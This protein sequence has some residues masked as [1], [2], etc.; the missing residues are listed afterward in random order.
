MTRQNTRQR[1]AKTTS[2]KPGEVVL[3]RDDLVRQ[4]WV[5]GNLEYKLWPQQKPIYHG[6][7]GLPASVSEAVFLCARQFGKSHLGVILAAE[8]C[9][10]F[11][12]SC[13]LIIGP[14]IKQTVGIVAPRLRAI[15]ARA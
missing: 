10:R 13:I 12:D 6:V 3:T 11:P 2:I 1:T 9:I 8:D 15:A 14:D 5:S 4:A 7:R